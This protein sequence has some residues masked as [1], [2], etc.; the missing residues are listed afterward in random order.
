MKRILTLNLFFLLCYAAQAQQNHYRKI[1]KI[2]N[3]AYAKTADFPYVILR[4][5]E[6]ASSQIITNKSD[7]KNV[8]FEYTDTLVNIITNAYLSRPDSLKRIPSQ[9][10]LFIKDDKFYLDTTRQ[11]YSGPFIN[12][13]IN[14]KKEVS[15]TILNG[16][17]EGFTYIFYM[18]GNLKES[19]YYHAGKRDS[20]NEEYFVDGILKS[21]GKY[22]EGQKE[23]GWQAWYSNGEIKSDL[24]FLHSL[25][26]VDG[27]EFEFYRIFN[28]A[29]EKLNNKN[30]RAAIRL[31]NQCH[32]LRTDYDELYYFRGVCY[33][34]LKK[35]DEA[36]QDF[37]D[38]LAIEPQSVDIRM[39]KVYVG[40]LVLNMY[41]SNNYKQSVI[42][43]LSK[44]ICKDV[45]KLLQQDYYS[46]ELDEITSSA[47][48]DKSAIVVKPY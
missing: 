41:K 14:G 22:K 9:L 40:C 31:F 20:T 46:L 2:N 48:I 36:L 1:F 43:D 16:L 23:E 38:G 7:L 30:Y 24:F 13:Y 39:Q 35:Y 37:N 29:L 6:V 47:C 26:I 8:G 15:G 33:R 11:P 34:M 12:Y 44:E 5:D 28:D 42:A 17:M 3:I 18:N 19:R 32:D 27:P 10:Q 25:A 45:Q 4:E 21:K